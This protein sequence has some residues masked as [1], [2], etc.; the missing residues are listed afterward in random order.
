MD[1]G[2]G[3]LGVEGLKLEGGVSNF[4]CKLVQEAATPLRYLCWLQVASGNR[5]KK[6]SSMKCVKG[7]SSITSK[8]FSS[9]WV[10]VGKRPANPNILI[11]ILHHVLNKLSIMRWSFHVK[12]LQ[13]F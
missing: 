11:V 4:H 10:R 13:S 3:G 6:G 2:N 12:F 9:V 1:V 5:K 8:T 7:I